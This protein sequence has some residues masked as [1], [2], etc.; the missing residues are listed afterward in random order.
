MLGVA[1]AARA[2]E[3]VAGSTTRALVLAFVLVLAAGLV[4]GACIGLAQSFLL[5]RL[6]PRLRV[7]NFIGMTVLA[8]GLGWTVGSLPMLRA[9]EGLA[10][11]GPPLTLLAIAGLGFGAALGGLLGICQR[12]VLLKLTRHSGRWVVGSVVAWAVA[13]AVI[14]LGAS[15]A[16]ADWPLLLVLAWAALTGTLAGGVVGALLGWLAPSLDGAAPANRV[17]LGLLQSRD[18]GP[19]GTGRRR[20]PAQGPAHGPGDRAPGDVRG[21]SRRPRGG[22]GQC[23]AQAVV[24]QSRSRRNGRARGEA[25]GCLPR[26]SPRSSSG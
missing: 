24:A 23:P 25:Q 7:A 17:V 13:M 3:H 12:A 19:P 15:T 16:A 2:A 6:V 26:T 9:G 22:G 18:A 20:P 8:A 5:R 21:P 14:M 11:S 1:A 10:G 4:E